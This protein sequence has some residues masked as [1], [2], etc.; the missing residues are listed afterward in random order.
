M[1]DYL[2][3]FTL[4]TIVFTNAVMLST[5]WSM[6]CSFGKSHVRHYFPITLALRGVIKKNER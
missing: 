5:I 6:S 1:S 3:L 2:Q 4:I